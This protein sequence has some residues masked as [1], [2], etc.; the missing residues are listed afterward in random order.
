MSNVLLDKTEVCA[1][2]L[3]ENKANHVAGCGI[4]S[5]EG[6]VVETRAASREVVVVVVVVRVTET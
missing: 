5:Y 6:P 4:L 1:A 2:Q 3:R